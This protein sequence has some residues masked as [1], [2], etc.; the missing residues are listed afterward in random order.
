M[1][2]VENRLYRL[3][4]SQLR[5]LLL[6]AKSKDGIISA[7]NSSVD[8]GKSG[9]A[10]GGVFSSLAR[11]KIGVHHFIMPWGKTEDGRDLRWKLNENL[12]S[13]GLLLKVIGELSI[14]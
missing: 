1:S 14:S 11:Q 10:L 5:A 13:K 4:P 3:S 7:S 12:V 6:F 8:I 2:P 9:K